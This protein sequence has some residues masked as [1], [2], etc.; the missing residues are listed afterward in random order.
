MVSADF[1]HASF[2]ILCCV[3]KKI[4]MKNIIFGMRFKLCCSVVN[5][6]LGPSLLCVKNCSQMVKV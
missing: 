4:K 3:V 5:N 6:C 2:N 1:E